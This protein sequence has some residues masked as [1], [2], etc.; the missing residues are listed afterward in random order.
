MRLSFCLTI[1]SALALGA[2]AFAE[3]DQEVAA[4]QVALEL[5]GAFSNDG[6]KLRDGHWTG[7]LARGESKVIA[8]NLYAGNEYW[9]SAG[10]GGK[11]KKVSVE[12]FDET[13][14]PVA[15]E[16]FD[17]GTKAASGVSVENSGEYFIRVRLDEGEPAGV[18]FVYS[19]K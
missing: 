15:G 19:Y 9:F 13:G 3:T 12:V 16:K 8:V 2:S 6:F 18:C 5:A 10:A 1:L 4:R 7:T 11:A 14:A 17:S